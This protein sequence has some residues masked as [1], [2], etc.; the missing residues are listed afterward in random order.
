[1]KIKNAESGTF[2]APE[3]GTAL[4]LVEIGRRASYVSTS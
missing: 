3:E 1:M 2:D 4:I